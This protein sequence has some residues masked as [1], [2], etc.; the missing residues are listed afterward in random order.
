MREKKRGKSAPNKRTKREEESRREEAVPEEASGQED[1]SSLIREIFS[2]LFSH[3]LFDLF[4]APRAL[5]ERRGMQVQVILGREGRSTPGSEGGEDREG[6]S[7][8]GSRSTPQ[9]PS[10]ETSSDTSV[11][12]PPHES[13]SPLLSQRLRG[14]ESVTEEQEE[15]ERRIAFITRNVFGTLFRERGIPGM[16]EAERSARERVPRRENVSGGRESAGAGAEEEALP[17]SFDLG[18]FFSHPFLA[19]EPPSNGIVFTVIYYIEDEPKKPKA[20]SIEELDK[21]SPEEKA[22]EKKSD[23]SICLEGIN[24]GDAVRTLQC[25]HMFHS[26]CVS[27]WL[28]QYANECPM[29][30]KAAVD[31]PEEEGQV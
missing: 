15:I 25:K 28:T 7:G 8:S 21:T 29:C 22:L 20:V 4:S 18:G 30:R 13:A 2:F 19:Q 6:G 1:R 27:E 3:T 23:C 17:S 24:T 12:P 16:W 31:V 9:T 14:E 26:K 10:T 5:R 11:P